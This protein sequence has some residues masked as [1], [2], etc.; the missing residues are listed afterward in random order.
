[1]QEANG[2]LAAGA[3]DGVDVR[4]I[5]SHLAR[6]VESPQFRG[7]PKLSRFL[8]FVVDTALADQGVQPP[9]ASEVDRS[10]ATMLTKRPGT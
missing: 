3:G 4:L 1:M 10:Q 8:T 2:V 9:R 5:R 6:V 7:A